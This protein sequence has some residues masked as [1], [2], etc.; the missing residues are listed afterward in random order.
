MVLSMRGASDRERA[1]PHELI[2][3]VRGVGVR[4]PAGDG[5]LGPRL[6]ARILSPAVISGGRCGG[7]ARGNVA[8]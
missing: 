3:K 8:R 7:G 1:Q 6:L 5:A 2:A 4:L